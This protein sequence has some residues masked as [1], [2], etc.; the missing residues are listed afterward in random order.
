VAY[1]IITARGELRKGFCFGRLYATFLLVYELTLEPLN[2]FAPNSQGN[3]QTNN[4]QTNNKT[5]D[6]FGPTLGSV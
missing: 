3:K 5:E 4:K 6:V 2:G 1:R